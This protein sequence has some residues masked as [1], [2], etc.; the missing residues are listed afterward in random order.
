ME[1]LDELCEQDTTD[2]E[3]TLRH[4]RFHDWIRLY[5]K[6]RKCNMILSDAVLAFKLLDKAKFS[7]DSR[8]WQNIFLSQISTKTI[9]GGRFK[10]KMW[11]ITSDRRFVI[12]LSKNQPTC[13]KQKTEE[14][15]QG[16][17]VTNFSV[18]PINR[19]LQGKKCKKTCPVCQSEFHWISQCP[20]KIK[21]VKTGKKDSENEKWMKNVIWHCILRMTNRKEAPE[22]RIIWMRNYWC[23]MYEDGVSSEVV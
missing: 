21:Q 3:S 7:V 6:C 2:L 8:L 18:N 17:N 19:I 23:S 5:N 1:S 22:D 14:I 9:L 15:V 12:K 10:D 13:Q 4:D 20:H 11:K 16:A